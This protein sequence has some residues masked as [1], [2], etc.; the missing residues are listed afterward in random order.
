MPS[1]STSEHGDE[2]RLLELGDLADRP[3]ASAPELLRRHPA[4][5]PETLDGEWVQEVELVLRRD[6]EEAV[7][8]RDSACDLR[9]E[10]RPSY[11]NG[12]RQADVVEH[13]LS[14]ARGDLGRRPRDPQIGRAHV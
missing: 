3:D 5:S 8:L 7:R 14:Q 11:T 6:H 4:D 2:G 12:D 13:R 10:L 1:G 9:K